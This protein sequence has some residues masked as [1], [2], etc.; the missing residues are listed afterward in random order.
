MIVSIVYVFILDFGYLDFGY[1]AIWSS[2]MPSD[3][4]LNA[5]HS[6]SRLF[7]FYFRDNG[8]TFL[9]GSLRN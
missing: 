4:R 7:S 6:G 2:G 5:R 9:L 1:L 8:S 3:F